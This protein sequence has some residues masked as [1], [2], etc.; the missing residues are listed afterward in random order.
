MKYFLLIITL[1]LSLS[2]ADD[3]ARLFKLYNN[4]NYQAVCEKGFHLFQRN[5]HDGAF[6]SLYAYGCLNN[7]SIDRLA[8]PIVMLKLNED[9][10]KNAAYFS[11]I[12]MKKK[13]LYHALLDG[14]DLTGISL[15]ASSYILSLVFDLYVQQS[16]LEI[17]G[18]YSLTDNKDSSIRY[19]LYLDKHE[20]VAQMIIEKY[21][22]NILVKRHTYW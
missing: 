13:L 12:L 3:K 11:A 20:K 2:L 8:T 14:Y 17:E 15:P 22:N 4:G 7:D 18:T 19:S 9:D 10:R 21:K 16:P 1:T 6:I 5:R